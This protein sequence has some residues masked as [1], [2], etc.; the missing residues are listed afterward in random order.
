MK[1]EFTASPED[2]AVYR[3]GPIWFALADGRRVE[4][5]ITGKHWPTRGI[6]LLTDKKHDTEIMGIFLVRGM[7]EFSVGSEHA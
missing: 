3:L 1:I 2:F 7:D 4:A 6:T 5:M